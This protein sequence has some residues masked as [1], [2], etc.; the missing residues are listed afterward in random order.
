MRVTGDIIYIP[1]PYLGSS[2]EKNAS[3]YIERAVTRE[4]VHTNDRGWRVLETDQ[5]AQS[6]DLAFIGCSWPMGVGVEAKDSFVFQ[7]QNNTGRA[8]ANLGIGS[9]SLLQAIRRLEREIELIQPKVVVLCYGHWLVNRCFKT[10]AM[11]DVIM[12]P[13]YKHTPQNTLNL[14][15]PATASKKDIVNFVHLFRKQTESGLSVQE[16]LVWTFLKR[17]LFLVTKRFG[18][19]KFSSLNYVQG[20]ENPDYFDY[21]Q[22]VLEQEAEK[23]KTL[24]EKNGAKLLV[25]H[26]HQYTDKDDHDVRAIEEDTAF[27]KNVEERSNDIF[28][29]PPEIMAE[30]LETYLDEKEET[31]L[32]LIHCPDNNH[33]NQEGHRLIGLMMSQALER[34]LPKGTQAA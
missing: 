30:T 28:Y 27:W 34:V 12:R 21:R 19:N 22:H 29:V 20:P 3:C 32:E 15:E 31:L 18:L 33:P 13:V 25:F 5:K 8:A 1:D 4:H 9:Y 24:C 23:L 17:K 26:F 7:A 16:K 6:C 11:S 10:N 14:V 2:L